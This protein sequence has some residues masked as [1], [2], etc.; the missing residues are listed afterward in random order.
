MPKQPKIYTVKKTS[1]RGA[2]YTY[3]GTVTELTEEFSGTL[4]SGSYQNPRINRNPKT[5]KSLLNNL[6]LSVEA[7]QG[8]CYRRD[9]YEDAT[10]C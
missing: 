9:R 1:Q 2:V 5:F 10:G 6:G 8:A 7:H 4:K 3:K